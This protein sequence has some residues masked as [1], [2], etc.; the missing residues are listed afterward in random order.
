VFI[1][2]Y[3]FRLRSSDF[4]HDAY[5]ADTAWLGPAKAPKL[6]RKWQR[7][8]RLIGAWHQV[9]PNGSST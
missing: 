2:A 6:V 3:R 1:L 9:G 8:G 5:R 7:C 4:P